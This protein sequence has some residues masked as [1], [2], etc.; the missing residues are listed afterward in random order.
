[1]V[2]LSKF[3]VG[4][5]RLRALPEAVI[6]PVKSL[7]PVKQAPIP[8]PQSDPAV[9]VPQID[10]AVLAQIQEQF[11]IPVQ[12]PPPPPPVE[13][14]P[15][16]PP[17]APPVQVPPPVFQAEPV[18]APIPQPAPPPPPPP[19]VETAPVMPPSLPTPVNPP[20]VIP[21]ES[22]P[23]ISAPNE[24]PIVPPPPVQVP[25]PVVQPAP[26]PP[27]PAAVAPPPPPPPPAVPEISPEVL[28]QIQQQFNLPAAPPAPPVAP[29]VQVPPPVM[30]PAPPPAAVA[31]PPPPPV[32][33]PPPSFVD[34]FQEPLNMDGMRGGIG[35]L[36]EAPPEAV[37]PPPVQVPPQNVQPEAPTNQR[38]TADDLVSQYNNSPGAQDFSLTATYDPATNTFIEDVSAFGFEGDAATNTYTPEEFINK[39]GYESANTSF[40]PPP[41]ALVNM[42]NNSPGAQDFSLTATY[43]PETNTYVEDVSAFGFEGD[44]A[45]NTYTPEE[46]M[47]RLGYGDP[48]PPVQTPPPV[49]QPEPAPAPVDPSLYSDPNL[50]VSPQSPTEQMGSNY[51]EPR[52]GPGFGGP[53]GE[54][55]DPAGPRGAAGL[56]Q[57]PRPELSGP[58]GAAGMGGD[59]VTGIETMAPAVGFGDYINSEVNEAGLPAGA[60]TNTSE[61]ITLPDGSTFDLGSLDLSGIGQG[62]GGFELGNFEIGNVDPSLYS[63]PNLGGGQAPPAGQYT[64]GQGI[65]EDGP[66]R[67]GFDAG[68]FEPGFGLPLDDMVGTTPNTGG[69]LDVVTPDLSG[70]DLSG[71]NINLGEGFD[72][73]GFEPDF[74]FG[75]PQG[76][77]GMGNGPGNTMGNQGGNQ[78]GDPYNPTVNDTGN[79][80]PFIPDGIDTSQMT[81]D[82]LAGLN[83]F[84]ENGGVDGLNLNFGGLDGGG[85]YTGTGGTGTTDGSYTVTPVDP[86]GDLGVG[87]D[88]DGASDPI[89]VTTPYVPPNVRAAS[90]YGLTGA[91]Q[92]MPVSANPFVRPESQQGLGSLAGGG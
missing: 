44:A 1:M 5:N 38:F 7:P 31:P 80:Y 35:S 64:A 76:G 46:F 73:S 15:P 81:P 29:P 63:D 66:G 53:R 69:G 16:P 68:G 87:D 61:S 39:L 90:S 91:T 62:F 27:P 78:G 37:A 40:T 74:T 72:A 33:V 2:D 24:P 43:D 17:V 19:P 34:E 26:P 49:M 21:G 71:L 28:A 8:V 6:P 52:D 10:P 47:D 57:G 4:G 86:V 58:S 22:G 85:S 18:P 30:Q 25:P 12:A 32:Q 89:D 92:T 84:Y 56:N 14:A 65:N 48:Q 77:P 59:D 51:I 54:G 79:P 20:K 88:T 45:T 9:S 70:L 42:Y 36:P 23:I 75:G 3:M 13:M 82:Q 55:F 83:T 11:N 41:E 60:Q 67:G 50:G